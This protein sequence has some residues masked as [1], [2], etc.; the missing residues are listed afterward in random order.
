M[1][2]VLIPTKLDPIAADTLRTHGFDVV[3]EPK[4]PLA[5]L[6]AA[7]PDADA[8]IVRSEK[9]DGDLLDRL[10]ELKLIVRAGAGYENIDTK[11]AR[12]RGIDVMNTPGANANAVAE[13]VVTLIL[14]AYRH[15]VRGDNTTRAGQ[16][17]KNA[18]MGRELAGKT[19]GIVG[20]G[21]IGQLLVKRLAGFEVEVLAYDPVL[22][23]QRAA[24]L[25]VELCALP[26]LFSRADI[27][28]LHIPET[29]E[30]RGL[31]NA[32]LLGR[33][34]E[35]ALL[36]NCARAGVINED[37]LRAARASRRLGYCTDVYPKDEPGPKSVADIADV[38]LP[39]VGASTEEAN[40]T[41]ARRA[42]EQAVAYFASGVTTY[43][44]NRALPV[45]LDERYQ[46]LAYYVTRVARGFL[47]PGVQP[48]RIEASFYGD[49]RQYQDFLLASVVLGLSSGFDPL[50]DHQQAL[51]YLAEKGIAYTSRE[52]DESKGY[53]NS[54]TIDLMESS[55]RTSNRCSVRG[56]IAEGV[57]MVSR[58]NDFD[59]LYFEPTGHS[60]LVVYQDQPGMLATITQ[61]MADHDTNIDDI[62][63]PHDPRTGE[64]LAALKVNKPVPDAALERIL[65]HPGFRRATAFTI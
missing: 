24:E 11:H 13:E 9:V 7:H 10:G 32:E 21:N 43:V 39:H 48:Q 51:Q 37:D 14:A 4:T 40:A 52:T 5:D 61:V 65:A 63:S 20:M 58:L 60:V 27:I 26:D 1:R 53:G 44:V 64:S 45:G 50:F 35:G 57:P 34:K 15:V 12:R 3:Q 54:I 19:V 42:A 29:P 8:L 36:I 30:T 25:E 28:S 31:V 6:A 62:R 16:W 33:M 38:M 18:L 46:L 47:G 23:E 59:R 56:T 49:L 17:E 41:A 22:S 55:N 2:K